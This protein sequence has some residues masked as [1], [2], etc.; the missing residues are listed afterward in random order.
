MERG[1]QGTLV[2]GDEARPGGSLVLRLKSESCE[3]LMKENGRGGKRLDVSEPGPGARAPRKFVERGEEL[4]PECKTN[5][6]GW[7]TVGMKGCHEGIVEVEH[8]NPVAETNG[9]A[10]RELKR[11]VTTPDLD[12]GC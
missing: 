5:R 10:A 12:A 2:R 11:S 9:R 6:D 3:A 4:P 8:A 1:E 7:E